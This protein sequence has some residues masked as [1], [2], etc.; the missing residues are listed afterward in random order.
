MIRPLTLTPRPDGELVAPGRWSPLIHASQ[1]ARARHDLRFALSAS[2]L[3]G[4]QSVTAY[5]L[6]T[7]LARARARASG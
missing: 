2:Y 4:D 7:P 3:A 5:D 6:A 1:T